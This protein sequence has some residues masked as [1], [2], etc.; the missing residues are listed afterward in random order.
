MEVTF[1][2]FS[3]SARADAVVTSRQLLPPNPSVKP[4][5]IF[6]GPH[7]DGFPA[8]RDA[9]DVAASARTAATA[10]TTAGS[11]PLFVLILSY[12]PSSSV[13]TGSGLGET[14]GASGGRD[15]R[16]APARG[17]AGERAPVDA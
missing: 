9:D 5:L 14:R 3:A 1:G 2:H 16:H 6:F 11:E 15:A 4:S 12:L 8:L 17:A 7:H 10:S 13:M